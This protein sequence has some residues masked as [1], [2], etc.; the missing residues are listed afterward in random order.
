[1][2]HEG[3]TDRRLIEED[4]RRMSEVMI[5]HLP[6]SASTLR[7][8]DV[9]GVAGDL[10]RQRRA[11]LAVTVGSS[12]E[13][14]SIDAVVAYD[15]ALTDD[16]L[17]SL[18]V[19]LRPGGRLIAV[20]PAGEPSA[21]LVKRLESAGYTRILVEE[22]LPGVLMRGEKPHVTDDTLARIE[23]VASRD[24]AQAEYR[25]RYLHLLIRQTPN[26]PVWALKPGEAVA[27]EA[28]AL[29]GDGEPL[30]LAFSSLPKAVAFMQ[31]A[32][33]S[34]QIKDVNK[35]AKFS[36]AA[37]AEGGWKLLVNPLAEA[38]DNG[39]LVMIPVDPTLAETPDE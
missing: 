12:A 26:K 35:V 14:D 6:P 36:R 21:A 9:N 17:R 32:V 2:P 22:M 16:A 25:G 37:A 7:L 18:L 33:L 30:L 34:G 28:V 27:W 8:L 3:V 29:A 15:A 13:P 31:P 20:D 24:P 11:D 10:L 1:V 19:A 5:K 38:L 23:S 4:I 39:T